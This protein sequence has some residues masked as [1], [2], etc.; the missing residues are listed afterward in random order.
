MAT[1]QAFSQATDLGQS[2]PGES[3]PKILTVLYFYLD[4]QFGEQD[5]GRAFLMGD[6]AHT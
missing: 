3:K 6:S 1:N 5:P 2:I 4:S